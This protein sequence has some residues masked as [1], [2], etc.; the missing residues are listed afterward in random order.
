MDI[1]FFIDGNLVYSFVPGKY[2]EE[3][4]PFK[5]PFYFLINMAVGGDFGGPEVDNS[6]FPSKFYIDYIKVTEL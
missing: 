6:I 3:H 2:D 5:K 1:K 4:F